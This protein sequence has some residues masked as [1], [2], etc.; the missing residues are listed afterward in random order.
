MAEA[1][2][3]TSPAAPAPAS[4]R[5]G[6]RGADA[7]LQWTNSYYTWRVACTAALSLGSLLL[8]LFTSSQGFVLDLWLAL[9]AL[10][11][12]LGL[13][14]LPG[15]S[16]YRVRVAEP[17]A[18]GSAA[19]P[20]TT[21]EQLLGPRAV[22]SLSLSRSALDAPGVTL[23]RTLALVVFE[24]IVVVQ[25]VSLTWIVVLMLSVY[26]AFGD[27]T[28]HGVWAIW[29]DPTSYATLLAI[30]T[31]ALHV[32]QFDQLRAHQQLQLGAGLDEDELMAVAPTALA[33]ATAGADADAADKNAAPSGVNTPILQS[34]HVD[35]YL[36]LNQEL[37]PWATT[38]DTVRTVEK[39]LRGALYDAAASGNC[40]AVQTLL[41][42][43]EHVLGSK[44]QLD[45]LLNRMYATPTLVCW[46]FSHRTHNPLHVACRA[47]DARVVAV[48]LEAGLNPNFLDKISGATLNLELMYE[49]CQLRVK[50]VTHVLGAPLH[51]AALHGH[52]QVIDLLVRF[53][54]NLDILARSSF[55]SRSMRVTPIFLADSADVVEC[56]I[57]HR[58]NILLVPG[59]GNA[60]C[61]TVLQ[62]AQLSGRRELATVLEEWGADVALTPLHEA[63]AAGNLAAVQHLLSW[64]ISPDV[65]GEFQRGVNSRTPLHWAAVMGRHRVIS[66]LVKHGAD[67]N[68][69]DSHG[70]TALH[71]AARHNYAGAVE[72]LLAVGADY[73]QL[74]HDGMTPLAFAVDGGLLRSDCVELFVRFG[75][76]VNA[77]VPNEIEETPLHI[78]L[79]L[80]YKDTALALLVEGKAD[81]YALNGAG[82]RAVECCASAEL[83]YAVKVAGDCV[84]VVLSFDPLFR[85]FAERVRAG[86]EQNFMTVY[87]RNEAEDA[88]GRDG[89]GAA[90]Y[91]LEVMKN[92]S[93]IVCML[94]EGYAQSV[95]CMDELAF[96]KQHEVPVVPISCE[97]VK[98]S[99]E[100][101]L[102]VFTRQ[103]VP[104]G[105]AV[106]SHHAKLVDSSD[107]D[108]TLSDASC[109]NHVEFEIDEDKFQASLRSLIDGLR[110]E[111]EMHRLGGDRDF[112]QM[113]T[114]IHQPLGRTAT[115]RHRRMDDIVNAV[116]VR[117]SGRR[118][119]FGGGPTF[120]IFVSHGDCHRDFV[121]QL[122]TELRRHQLPFVVDSMTN[123][124]STKERILAAK[125][126]ILQSS[127]FLVLLSERSVKTELV[128]DQ[129]A[130]A[131]DKGKTIVPI[132]FSKRPRGV[133]SALGRLLEREGRGYIFSSDISYGRGLGELLHDLRSREYENNFGSG[134]GVSLLSSPVAQ[135]AARRLLQ[136]SKV[137]KGGGR[138]Q[139]PR[140]SVG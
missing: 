21:S 132:Y 106:T 85:P 63:A 87:M 68:A 135:A 99:E 122:C 120:S 28:E 92:A 98:M 36:T 105:Q 15:V 74:D 84:D 72:E 18:D 8:L 119:T 96:A 102:F 130:F 129:L 125:D 140:A 10:N 49:L 78:A 20:A 61:T 104:F 112:A 33:N 115:L 97:A 5:G 77:L 16:L 81:L 52:T 53:G 2:A 67:V 95:L 7:Q 108:S 124:S 100:L 14:A 103:I 73:L 66:E 38:Q 128:S 80:G 3:V 70:R 88:V 127:V 1:A 71:W 59:S 134:A 50:K 31:I 136:N 62:R 114:S 44:M 83:Q 110:D 29:T 51:V 107:D 58:A 60:A 35:S 91:S 41:E 75:T 139:P 48:L 4:P 69:K 19:A 13:A 22:S 101:Q 86:I 43:A 57:R 113:T 137:F 55:F 82:R 111:V 47:G 118:I 131:E 25:T 11:V 93:A 138:K 39:Q 40:A 42:R 24:A 45:M 34:N 76:D 90:E 17:P 126:A 79:R 26:W 12:S 121:T 94:S 6:W 37:H 46:M 116:V 117:G 23:E 133:D 65:L 32:R 27:L 64:G 123:V 89:G 56:L 54:A 109:V 9:Q 30:L